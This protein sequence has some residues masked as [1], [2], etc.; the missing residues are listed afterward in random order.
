MT[1]MPHSD[2]LVTVRRMLLNNGINS[3][4]ECETHHGK[5]FE[6]AASWLD[7]YWRQVD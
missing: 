6:C 4:I 3:V 7:A 2:C 5:R 1:T